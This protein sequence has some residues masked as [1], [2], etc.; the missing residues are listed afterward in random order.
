ME[1]HV[2]LPAVLTINSGLCADFHKADLNS[3][4][5]ISANRYKNEIQEWLRTKQSVKYMRCITTRGKIDA[6]NYSVVINN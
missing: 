6:I 2:N 1:F 5:I 4:N 3:P